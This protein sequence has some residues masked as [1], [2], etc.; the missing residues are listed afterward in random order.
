[1]KILQLCNRVPFPLKDGGAIC[2]YNIYKAYYQAGNLVT[3]FALNTKKHWV[4]EK[5]V[6]HNLAAFG[7]VETAIID[8]NVTLIGAVKNLFSYDSYHVSRFDNEAVHQKIKSILQQNEFDVIHIDTVFMC[9]YLPTIR[10]YS[11]AKIVLR[12]HNVEHLIWHRL[13]LQTNGIKKWYL[14]LQPIENL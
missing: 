3:L 14:N 8:T 5:T 1:M 7:K 13:A 12:T 4:D 2:A 11:H 9:P 10:K 6:Q